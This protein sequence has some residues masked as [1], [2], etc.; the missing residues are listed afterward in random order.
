MA[1][2]PNEFIER[3]LEW[4]DLRYVL[5]VGKAGSV[6]GAGRAL[7]V[8]H[9]TVFRRLDKIERTLGVRLFD[10]RQSG[11]VAT[12]IGREIVEEAEQFEDRI[13][14]LERRVWG[15]DAAIKGTVRVTTTDTIAATPLPGIIASLAVKHPQLRIEV[16]I[17]NESFNITKHDADI[18]IRFGTRPPETLVGHRVA[19][20]KHAV[21]CQ[22]ACDDRIDLAAWQWVAPNDIASEL[23]VNQW[24]RNEGHDARVVYRSNSFLAEVMAVRAGVGVG[25]LA[26]F[27]ADSFDGLR[28]LTPPVAGVENEYWVLTHPELRS[29]A[30]VAAVY[31]FIRRSFVQLKPLFSG[32]TLPTD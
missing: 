15:Q 1:L 5:A 30:R 9:V 4:D 28:K 3:R 18:A 26:C 14:A 25:L 21:Y 24:L 27:V 10:R 6:A 13:N 22:S 7:R 16:M 12:P 11:Y 31:A 29:V 20:V 32:D 2:E 8:S 19:A 17:S 23:Q